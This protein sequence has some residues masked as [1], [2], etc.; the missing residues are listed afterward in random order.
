[1]IPQEAVLFSGTIRSNLDPFDQLTDQEC[2]DALARVRMIAAPVPA[3]SAR[4][5]RDASR[6]H[7]R[8][9]SPTPQPGPEAGAVANA[10]TAGPNA[11]L[12]ANARAASITSSSE[13]TRVES[14]TGRINVTL[15][16]PV[17]AGGHNFSAGQRQL[18][19]LARALL[20]RAKVIIMDESTAS[21]DL[22]SDARIQR[23]VQ[24]E[25]A[26]SLVITIAHRLLTIIDY[27]KVLVLDQGNIVEYD[28]P[29][30]LLLK[31]GGAFRAMCEK[32]ADWDE[33]KHRIGL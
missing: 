24:E 21:V 31:E 19:A 5:S 14:S 23:T 10:A 30:A 29:R 16:T 18:L 11:R 25:F 20:R 27:D 7:S 13:S 26:D 1:M 6:E 17:S 15:D 9:P 28:S 12:V 4:E 2:L 3:P 8:A 33:L 22:E 32:S